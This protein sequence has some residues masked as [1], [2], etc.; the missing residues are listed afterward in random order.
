MLWIHNLKGSAGPTTFHRRGVDY[1]HYDKHGV[2]CMAQK[3]SIDMIHM[4]AC[5]DQ[6]LITLLITP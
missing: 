1:F 3:K 2:L 4:F 5:L 6:K